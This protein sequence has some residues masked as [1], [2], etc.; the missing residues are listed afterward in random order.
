[1]TFLYGMSFQQWNVHYFEIQSTFFFDKRMQHLGSY[2]FII[3]FKM[4]SILS[5]SSL[6]AACIRLVIMDE[7]QSLIQ[8]NTIHIFSCKMHHT[9]GKSFAVA[10]K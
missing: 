10:K 8:G 4:S 1:M 7:K 5:F 3:I 9:G 6:A 2:F